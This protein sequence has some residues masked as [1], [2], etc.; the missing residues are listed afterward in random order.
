MGKV[1]ENYD[2][3]LENFDRP[4]YKNFSGELETET[5]IVGGGI[6]GVLT[7]YLLAKEGRPVVLLEKARLGEWVTDCTT[8]FLTQSIDTNYSDLLKIFGEEKTRLI[9]QSHASAIGLIEKIIIEE[10]IDCEFKRVTNRI[11]ART[12]KEITWLKK[13]EKIL[14]SFGA[15]VCF[16]E[17]QDLNFP[18]FGYLEL[19]NQA[20]FHPMKFLTA[21]AKM[22]EELG[23]KIFEQSEVLKIEKQKGKWQV[24]TGAGKVTTK[25]LVVATYEPFGQPWPLFFKKAMYRSYVMEFS[26]PAKSLPDGLY[27]DLNKPYHYFKID[28]FDNNCRVIFGGEDHRN[29]LKIDRSKNYRALE[30]HAHQIFPNQN[31]SLVRKWSGLILE[32]IDGLPYIG[33]DKRSGIFYGFGFSGN[34]L[35]YSSITASLIAENISGRTG[36]MSKYQKIYQVNRWPNLWL[37]MIKGRDYLSIL[38]GG[39]LK[40]L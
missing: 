10:K 35:T 17:N 36:T 25:E 11:F 32:S 2:I 14:K 20:T 31:L 26:L 7:A 23:A 28:N 12:K 9:F 30:K 37:L 33:R 15:Q 22:V 1:G 34:G 19:E 40:N 3:W 39:W 24:E 16:R 5:V 29:D 38:L 8:G 13:E 27:E 4:E 21:L 6:T 18:N